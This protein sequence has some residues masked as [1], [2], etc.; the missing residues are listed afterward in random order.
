MNEGPCC[1]SSADGSVEWPS[2]RSFVSPPLRVSTT[3]PAAPDWPISS[4]SPDTE[5][6]ELLTSQSAKL[7]RQSQRIRLPP[8]RLRLVPP[9]LMNL[10]RELTVTLQRA[11]G[12]K[13]HDLFTKQDPYAIITCGARKQRSRVHK[14]G[15]SNPVWN[16]TFTFSVM[17]EQEIDV[18][19]GL[20]NSSS[21]CVRSAAERGSARPRRPRESSGSKRS[22]PPPKLSACLRSCVSPLNML[23]MSCAEGAAASGTVGLFR[24]STRSSEEQC[25]A[26]G[27]AAWDWMARHKHSDRSLGSALGNQQRSYIQR[28][29]A[30]VRCGPSVH[31]FSPL[32]SD[33]DGGER[34]KALHC[35][36]CKPSKALRRCV[37]VVGDQ[38]ASS[39]ASLPLQQ[40]ASPWTEI[41]T[42]SSGTTSAPSY[43]AASRCG[44]RGECRSFQASRPALKRTLIPCRR[45]SRRMRTWMSLTPMRPRGRRTPGSKLETVR[46]PQHSAWGA[47]DG[48]LYASVCVQACKPPACGMG[49]AAACSQHGRHACMH[50]C[51]H[52]RYRL[53]LSCLH[54]CVCAPH[55]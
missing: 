22:G 55:S 10:P 1:C 32:G 18:H 8:L 35:L 6:T 7:P 41:F 24:A 11:E 38:A 25:G 9:H 52:G 29:G 26:C 47:W 17:N 53:A 50:A 16:Q 48:Q 20:N 14:S 39:P 42:M 30:A 33:D 28:G 45:L 54:A 44:P 15:G 13:D 40:P 4:H 43:R 46:S 2:P 27:L 23:L 34:L 19:V 49:R 12:L 36:L 3:Y 5:Q 51:M 21:R 37:L 31:F